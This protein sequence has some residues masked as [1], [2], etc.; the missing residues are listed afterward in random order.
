L[1]GIGNKANRGRKRLEEAGRG[2]WGEFQVKRFQAWGREHCLGPEARRLRRSAQ[3]T[4]DP[5]NATLLRR[6]PLRGYRRVN[7][8]QAGFSGLRIETTILM[9]SRE[10]TKRAGNDPGSLRQI[11]MWFR[12]GWRA[13]QQQP[14]QCSRRWASCTRR[15]R[16]CSCGRGP[17]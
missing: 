12:T 17:A 16:R 7:G 6:L 10:G 9:H 8:L 3:L 11:G 14:Y 15:L 5:R 13:R 1:T 2:W 4:L